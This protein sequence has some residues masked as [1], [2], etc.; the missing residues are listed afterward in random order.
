MYAATS[1]LHGLITGW[2]TWIPLYLGECIFEHKEESYALGRRGDATCKRKSV[3]LSQDIITLKYPS[4][5]NSS[6][7]V[8]LRIVKTGLRTGLS[9]VKDLVSGIRQG[10]EQRTL[11]IAL[12]ASA[13]TR[14]RVSMNVNTPLYCFLDMPGIPWR[15]SNSDCTFTSRSGTSQQT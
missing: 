14:R 15:A 10:K 8:L 11:R 4:I 13:S 12:T 3:N 9:P 5:L 1:G 7:H 6:A 2:E